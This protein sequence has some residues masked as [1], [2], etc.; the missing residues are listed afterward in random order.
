M[1]IWA[2]G[3]CE[4][5]IALKCSCT[6]KEEEEKKGKGSQCGL[7]LSVWHTKPTKTKSKPTLEIQQFGWR[8]WRFRSNLRRVGELCQKHKILVQKYVMKGKINKSDISARLT[9]LRFGLRLIFGGGMSTVGVKKYMSSEVSS[10]ESSDGPSI[11]G[12]ACSAFWNLLTGIISRGK[13]YEEQ[14]RTQSKATLSFSYTVLLGEGSE[15]TAP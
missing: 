4:L 10:P 14:M 13:L 5:P 15:T 7:C 2:Y 1:S 8:D 11:L 3:I 12:S 9:P 6:K